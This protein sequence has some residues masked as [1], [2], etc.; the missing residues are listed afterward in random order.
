MKRAYAQKLYATFR[1]KKYYFAT[2][3]TLATFKKAPEAFVVL[4]NRFLEEKEESSL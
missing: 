2:E 1:E 4:Y 3:K